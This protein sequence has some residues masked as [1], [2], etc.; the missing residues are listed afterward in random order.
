MEGAASFCVPGGSMV[1]V[2]RGLRVRVAVV[3][4]LALGLFCI[5]GA[6]FGATA[7][8]VFDPATSTLHVFGSVPATGT[9]VG[10][11]ATILWSY[12]GSGAVDSAASY[13]NEAHPV[14]RGRGT[15]WFVSQVVPDY[16]GPVF[17]DIEPWGVSGPD[18]IVGMAFVG[19]GAATVTVSNFPLSSADATVAIVGTPTV[20]VVSV[21]PF[22]RAD[23]AFAWVLAVAL[24]GFGV[25]RW[26]GVRR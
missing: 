16:S 12:R 20:S 22:G 19:S 3:A 6:V 1:R 21:G 15:S 26:L 8:S 2:V 23:I 18:E 13:R 7:C 17:F 9:G 11:V 4:A 5:P 24:G 10:P 14:V 25:G